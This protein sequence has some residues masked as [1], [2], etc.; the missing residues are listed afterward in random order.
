MGSGVRHA[1]ADLLAGKLNVDTISCQVVGP[2]RCAAEGGVELPGKVFV[3]FELPE[4]RLDAR[5]SDGVGTFKTAL[6]DE[7]LDLARVGLILDVPVTPPDHP[8]QSTALL[9]VVTPG[10]ESGSD[11]D[12]VLFG[13]HLFQPIEVRLAAAGGEVVAVY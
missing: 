1:S 12:L 5:S 4:G 3:L 2:R 13:D 10:S 9:G 7:A 6:G 11:L 8:V